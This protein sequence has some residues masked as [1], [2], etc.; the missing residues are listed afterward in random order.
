MGRLDHFCAFLLV[1]VFLYLEQL[2]KQKLVMM[3]DFTLP[4][5]LLKAER[6]QLFLHV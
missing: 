1:H 5:A 3:I 6:D 2:A 4:F